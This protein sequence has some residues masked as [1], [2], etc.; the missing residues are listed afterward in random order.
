M[1]YIEKIVRH[2]FPEYGSFVDD[3]NVLSTLH[4]I[5]IEQLETDCE[6]MSRSVKNITDSLERGKLSNK[7]DLHPEDRILTTI[8]SPM[9]NAKTKRNVTVP[10]ETH[11]W[12]AQLVNDVLVKTRKMQLPETHSF[13][14][15]SLL[16]LNTRK[17][18]LKISKEKKSKEHTRSG[19]RFWKI[20]SPK[21][22]VERGTG[23]ARSGGRHRRRVV[24]GY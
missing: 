2:S 9:L 13:T 12:R 18:T 6:E 17:H 19:K 15:L 10:F 3:L 7:K 4:N 1:H 5:S 23:R 14:S 24:C 21:G 22:K 16:S 11:S 8:S 20:K